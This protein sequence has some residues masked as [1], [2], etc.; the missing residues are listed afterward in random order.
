MPDSR[1]E[2]KNRTLFK[3]KM[4]N[5]VTLLLTKMTKNYTLYMASYLKPVPG[6]LAGSYFKTASRTR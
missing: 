3:T 1:L 4:A 5:S 2:S 6:C